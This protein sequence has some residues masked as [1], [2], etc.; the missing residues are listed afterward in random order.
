MY[1]KM[2]ILKKLHSSF[3][4]DPSS[5]LQYILII[6]SSNSPSS[7]T[8]VQRLKYVYKKSQRTWE[9]SKHCTRNWLIRLTTRCSYALEISF[10]FHSEMKPT[11]I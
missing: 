7:L 11:K 9:P 2:T 1:M 3:K 4:W 6:I 8:Y 5:N 10:E